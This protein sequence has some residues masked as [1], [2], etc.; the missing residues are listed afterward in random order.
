MTRRNLLGCIMTI[1]SG[2]KPPAFTPYLVQ[3]RDEALSTIYGLSTRYWLDSFART[4]S[5][6]LLEIHGSSERE[7]ADETAG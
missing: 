4:K 6:L 5:R 7:L 2:K 1:I 3:K